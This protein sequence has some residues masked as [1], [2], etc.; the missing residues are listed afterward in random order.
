M[1]ST[2]LTTID[3][4]DD[5]VLALSGGETL[6]IESGSFNQVCV[7]A[8]LIFIP[9]ILAHRNAINKNLLTWSQDFTQSDWSKINGFIQ[10]GFLAPNGTLTAQKFT[11]SAGTSSSSPAYC[12]LLFFFPKK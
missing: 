6:Q 8:G 11:E 1:H 9:W 3:L 4:T 12:M 10:T 7:S 2:I 5:Q